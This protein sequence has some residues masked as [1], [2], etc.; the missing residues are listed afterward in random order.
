M[1]FFVTTAG[2]ERGVQGPASP[3]HQTPAGGPQGPPLTS[4]RISG[5]PVFIFIVLKCDFMKDL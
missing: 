5:L 3:W 4:R 2:L 1:H